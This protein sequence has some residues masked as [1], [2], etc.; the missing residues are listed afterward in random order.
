[1]PVYP[2]KGSIW[3]SYHKHAYR[4]WINMNVSPKP[5]KGRRILIIEENLAA[6][7]LWKQNTVYLE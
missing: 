3:K 5:I 7:D 6:L 1:M 4:T 2:E